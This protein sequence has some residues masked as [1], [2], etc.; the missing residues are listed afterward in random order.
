M[1]TA[2]NSKVNA[3]TYNWTHFTAVWNAG[4]GGESPPP[5]QAP[6]NKIPGGITLAS[7]LPCFVRSGMWVMSKLTL[8]SLT[9]KCEKLLLLCFLL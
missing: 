8:L 2:I 7:F 4:C 1:Y 5:P 6:G 9:S 3:G